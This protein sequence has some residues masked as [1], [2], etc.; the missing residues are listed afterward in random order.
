MKKEFAYI[1]SAVCLIGLLG[2]GVAVVQAEAG[3]GHYSMA[4]KLSEKLGVS[5]EAAQNAFAEI[6]GERNGERLGKAVESGVITEEQKAT[7][8]EHEEE[9]RAKREGLMDLSCEER[10]EALKQWREEMRTWAEENGI[11]GIGMRFGCRGMGSGGKLGPH[12]L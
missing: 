8:L 12:A 1:L 9:M 11:E 7:I 10:Q 2:I 5:V 3:T 4:Q 6:R